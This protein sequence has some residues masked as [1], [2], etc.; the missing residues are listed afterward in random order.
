MMEQPERKMTY[1]ER[2]AF[3]KE[4]KEFLPEIIAAA[5]EGKNGFYDNEEGVLASE[6]T[7]REL[8]AM[9]KRGKQE[10]KKK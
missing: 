7:I 1:S 5:G 4:N 8:L 2:V 10:E 9:R 6:Q 3:I